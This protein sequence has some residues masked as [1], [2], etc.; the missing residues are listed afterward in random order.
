MSQELA[1]SRERDDELDRLR[2]FVETARRANRLRLPPE[3]DLADELG[4][5]RS[6]LRVFLKKLE[7]EGL[8]WRHV[9][10]GTFVGERSLASDV[11]SLPERINP[12]EAFDARMVIEPVL[13]GA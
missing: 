9:G 5:T 4:V 11:G 10:K 8:I 2:E 13:D 6:R 7:S 12:L 1:A 3:P